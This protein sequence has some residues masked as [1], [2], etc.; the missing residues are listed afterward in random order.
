MRVVAG[1]RR[2]K[3]LLEFE[4]DYIR[5]TTDRVKEAV[6]N[7][8]QGRVEGGIVFDAFAGTGALGIE[9]VSRGAEFAV[10]TDI[11]ERSVSVIRK[12][13][14]GCGFSDRFEILSQALQQYSC[15]DRLSVYISSD[16]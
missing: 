1:I 3:K 8:I 13:V 14:D 10:A 15:C 6:F 2:G 7:L 12:N 11:D 9:A 16:I 4:G 5:P